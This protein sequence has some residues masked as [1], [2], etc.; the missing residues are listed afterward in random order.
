MLNSKILVLHDSFNIH[1]ILSK[2]DEEIIINIFSSGEKSEL[3]LCAW[4]IYLCSLSATCKSAQHCWRDWMYITCIIWVNRTGPRM[5]PCGTPLAIFTISL[6]LPIVTHWCL[7]KRKLW[8]NAHA[9][10][11]NLILRKLFKSKVWSTVLNAFERSIKMAAQRFSLLKAK[12]M[13]FKLLMRW[14][15][16]QM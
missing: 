5:E 6:I 4:R 12:I 13:L 15:C 16:H 3:F 10:S 7:F 9:V 11:S 1:T 14:P 2:D 8:N